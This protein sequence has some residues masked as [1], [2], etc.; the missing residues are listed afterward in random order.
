MRQ[1]KR[2]ERL[3]AN[4]EVPQNDLINPNLI[5][6]DCEKLYAL[7]GF[8]VMTNL[9]IS[10]N[11]LL[12]IAYLSDLLEKDFKKKPALTSVYHGT[13][14]HLLR[15]KAGVL[16]AAHEYFIEKRSSKSMTVKFF[17][18]FHS[19]NPD[20]KTLFEKFE[21]NCSDGNFRSFH[22]IRNNFAYHLNYSDNGARTKLA[23][24]GRLEELRKRGTEFLTLPGIQIGASPIEERY[25]IADTVLGKAL[26]LAHGDIPDKD[27]YSDPETQK[28]KEIVERIGVSYNTWG[29][30]SV[31]R[32]LEQ[33]G[34]VIGSPIPLK[35]LVK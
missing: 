6:V 3:R 29:K 4:G 26:R 34:V 13:L 12:S 8:E 22:V 23:I 7:P 9:M 15:N 2:F 10:L 32:Y 1:L 17:K 33:S 11:D 24:D 5:Y 31:K 14:M 35:S 28:E 20:L 27:D 21:K 18:D 16:W 30:A 25:I 19:R